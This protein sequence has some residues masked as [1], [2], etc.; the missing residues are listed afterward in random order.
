MPINSVEVSD[1]CNC[2]VIYD[3]NYMFWKVACLGMI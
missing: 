1:T 3:L 2:V